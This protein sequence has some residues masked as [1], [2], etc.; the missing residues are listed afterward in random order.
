MGKNGRNLHELSTFPQFCGQTFVKT[1]Q[2]GWIIF[3]KVC[4]T[5]F[6]KNIDIST[7]LYK[8]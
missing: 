7:L 2:I 8:I 4:K 6:F 5:W 3:I 1:L